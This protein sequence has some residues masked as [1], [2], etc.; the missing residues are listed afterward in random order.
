MRGLM[1]FHISTR[2]FI[3]VTPSYLTPGHD[4]FRRCCRRQCTARCRTFDDVRASCCIS[5]E[6]CLCCKPL[7]W[8]HHSQP[9]SV[10]CLRRKERICSIFLSSIPSESKQ[11]R[12]HLYIEAVITNCPCKKVVAVSNLMMSCDRSSTLFT[13]A[14]ITERWVSNSGYRV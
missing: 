10:V 1:E 6:R 11:C 14:Q 2:H 13:K 3:S 8:H 9:S 12:I 7:V 5:S 4:V